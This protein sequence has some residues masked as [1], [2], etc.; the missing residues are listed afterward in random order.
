MH[1]DN[2]I[3]KFMGNNVFEVKIVT[4]IW[5]GCVISVTVSERKVAPRKREQEPPEEPYVKDLKVQ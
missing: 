1:S 4:E 2:L 5:P 3:S